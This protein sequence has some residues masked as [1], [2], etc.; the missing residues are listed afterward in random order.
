MSW[1]AQP[2]SAGGS[3]HL[4]RDMPA[5]RALAGTRFASFR[6]V[7][8]PSARTNLWYGVH[9]TDAPSDSVTSTSSCAVPVCTTCTLDHSVPFHTRTA[10]VAG[11]SSRAASDPSWSPSPPSPRRW[12]SWVPP[13][14]GAPGVSG[15][16]GAF[17]LPAREAM[18]RWPRSVRTSVSPRTQRLEQRMVPRFCWLDLRLQASLYIMYG[19]P[20]SVCDSRIAVNRSRAF[21]VLRARPSR[22]CFVYSALNS[23]PHTSGNPGA[24]FGQN[25][26]HSPSAFTR[27]MNRSGIHSPKNRS[28]ARV[29][30]VPVFLRR[31]YTPPPTPTHTQTHISPINATVR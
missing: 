10:S 22:S 4:A 31:F 25:S 13:A 17:G 9:T 14:P 20:V 12:V 27:S 26:D 15:A 2:A 8:S 7:A 21:I 19:V 30:S 29:S 6:G 5:L 1:S 11:P 23:A 16:R 28:R 18:G 3:C 24:S